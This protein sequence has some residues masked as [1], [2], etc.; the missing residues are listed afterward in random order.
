MVI[1]TLFFGKLAGIP[2]DGVPYPVF[3]Y[4]GLLLWTFFSNSVTNSGNSLVGNANLLTKVYFPRMIIPGSAVGAG[5]VDF[6]FAF[7]V[8]VG[9]M[10]YYDVSLSWRALVAPLFVFLTTLLALG[11]GMWVSALNVKYR[12]VRYALPFL[13]Q[14]W[15]FVSPIIYPS[16]FLPEK[17]RWL[18]ALN[19]LTGLVEGFRTAMF[20][21]RP[22]DFRTIL[23]SS[24]F[25]LLMLVYATYTFRKME[26]TFADIV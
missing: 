8:L 3:V 9:L 25:T 15:M 17:W 5:L 26:R 24:V 18:L 1:F 20:G 22:L 11:I 13:I 21:T 10:V 12:D 6:V 2:S 23:I 7:V 14:L 16:S 19:P 4:T